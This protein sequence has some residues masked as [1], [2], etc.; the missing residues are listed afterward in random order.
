MSSF[1]PSDRVGC[2]GE[3]F[4]TV[5]EHI[6]NGSMPGTGLPLA[7]RS[8]RWHYVGLHSDGENVVADSDIDCAFGNGKLTVNERVLG[9][10]MATIT[11]S[12]EVAQEVKH[13]QTNTIIAIASASNFTLIEMYLLIRGDS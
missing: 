3:I 6:I 8:G 10:L 4:E 5:G 9:V 13:T 11:A 12:G 7:V 2:D 1:I